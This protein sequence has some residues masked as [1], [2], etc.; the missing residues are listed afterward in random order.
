MEATTAT[1][2]V[3]EFKALLSIARE[4]FPIRMR[5]RDADKLLHPNFLQSVHVPDASGL[6]LR[7]E[8]RNHL[9]SLRIPRPLSSL[10]WPADFIRWNR[11]AIVRFQTLV[12]QELVLNNNIHVFLL[13]VLNPTEKIMN[14]WTITC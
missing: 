12:Y 2:T 7:N 11:M 4:K 6:I 9:I 8:R 1:I 10:S 5:C 3:Q 13:R 14:P